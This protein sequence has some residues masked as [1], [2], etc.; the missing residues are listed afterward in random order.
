MKT[1]IEKCS[2][3]E[4]PWNKAA[5]KKVKIHEKLFIKVIKSEQ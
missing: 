1:S 2:E 3:N 5:W 4:V